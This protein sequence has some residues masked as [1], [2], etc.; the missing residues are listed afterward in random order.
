MLLCELLLALELELGA[1][2]AGLRRCE[3]RLGLVDGGLLGGD[4]LADAVDRRFLRGDLVARRFGGELVVAVID[5]RDD[6]AFANMGIVATA[7]SAT[8][9][10]TLA[11]S[12]AF[13]APT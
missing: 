1:L 8:Y 3:L 9:P 2:V 7:T 13:L 6:V 11:E 4:L 5:A 10:V 12:V